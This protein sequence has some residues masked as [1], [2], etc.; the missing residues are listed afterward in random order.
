MFLAKRIRC[1]NC[2]SKIKNADNSFTIKLKT[3]EGLHEV[4]MCFDCAH[5]FDKIAVELEEVINERFK[6]V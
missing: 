5:E 3:S 1:F 4:I 2:D 6:S